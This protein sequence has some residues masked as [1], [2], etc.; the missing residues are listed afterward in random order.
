MKSL[1]VKFSIKVKGTI[2]YSENIKGYK[3]E[4]RSKVMEVELISAVK[5]NIQKILSS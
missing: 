3:H 5:F 2:L 4:T 1:E